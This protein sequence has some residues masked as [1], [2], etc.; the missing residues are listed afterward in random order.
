MPNYVYT[1]DG[2]QHEIAPSNEF[3][4]SVKFKG[5]EI[6]ISEKQNQICRSLKKIL[7]KW[8][9]I[10][11]ELNIKWF[12]NGGTLLGTQRDKGL[13]FYDNDLDIVIQMKDYHKLVGYECGDG[14]VLTESEVGFNLSRNNSTFPFMDIW[15][16]G[17]DPNDDEKMTICGPIFDSVP[18]YYFVKVWPNEWY[19]KSDLRRLETA[20]F[21]DIEVFIP[22]NANHIL[23]R[24]Y[25]PT[26]LSEYRI[27]SHTEDHERFAG[28]L[29][30]V[31]NR[32]K[33]AKT[34]KNINNVLKLDRTSNQDGHLTSLIAKTITEL[35]AVSSSNKHERINRHI[36]D[37]FK[38][39]FD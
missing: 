18:M 22:K 13:I 37:F 26:C 36:L 1:M 14:F 23:H 4:D 11:T 31:E 10:A 33:L 29:T 16:I 3:P 24:M 15:A 9:R 21:E 5:N 12:V 2:I 28:R 20:M 38:A 27:E 19:Y 6:Y 32:V 30:N 34:I 17:K 39:Q 35:T 7:L 8:K 25:G